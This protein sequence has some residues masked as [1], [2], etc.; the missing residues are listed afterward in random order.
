[1][2]SY[3][4]PKVYKVKSLYSLAGISMETLYIIDPDLAD[5]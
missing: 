4:L 5:T 1:M 3:F 2:S